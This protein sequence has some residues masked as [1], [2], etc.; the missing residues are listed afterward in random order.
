MT[1]LTASGAAA[2]G[3]KALPRLKK[4]RSHLGLAALFLAPALL[5]LVIFRL[6]P[7]GVAGLGALY[8]ENLEG[9]Q[10]FVGLA[11]FASLF[12]DMGFWHSLRTTI[13]F[14]L[15]INPFQIAIS[16]A[17]A[18]L[19]LRPGRGITFF[20]AAFFLPMTLSIGLTA[21][22]WSMLL[23]QTLGPI[24]ALLEQLGFA[25][26]GFF[27]S[28]DQA[29][30]TMI[31]V[32]SWKGCGYWMVF[33]LAGLFGID[34]QLYEAAR[35]DGANS[36]QRFW[37]ITLP[38][39][40]RPLTFVLIADTAVNFLFFAPV[41][42]ITS[43]GPNDATSLMMFRAYEAAFTFMNWGRSLAYSSVI[44]LIVIGVAIVQ[45]KLLRH[46]EDES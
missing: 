29:L 33:L 42:I 12:E 20:R 26:Q 38:Q 15:I 30:G 27:R 4:P 23:D 43:G 7:I 40:R 6:A 32:A 46:G 41:Y 24:N 21:V 22:L 34:D 18:L 44:L 9:D 16:F 45:L 13:L 39:M 8:R 35:I 11:N 28:E 36:W 17:M 10:V 14:N 25:R 19:V 31:A 5:G 3:P 37:H 1:E 2:A